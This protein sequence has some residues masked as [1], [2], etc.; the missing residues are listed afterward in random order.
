MIW[1]K[2]MS[3]N[4][5][6]SCGNCK[7]YVVIG[8]KY[9]ENC[10]E[11][12]SWCATCHHHLHSNAAKF[13]SECGSLQ[14]A[15]TTQAVQVVDVDKMPSSVE[16]ITK[17][18]KPSMDKLE[19]MADEINSQSPI[20]IKLFTQPTG[21]EDI[22]RLN[23]C[24]M[25]LSVFSEQPPMYIYFNITNIATLY[26]NAKPTAFQMAGIEAANHVRA[27]LSIVALLAGHH[28]RKAL[29]E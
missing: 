29:E 19:Y 18:E 27:M 20:V 21:M 11:Q 10:G 25:F 15:Q 17:K 7:E 13:C 26:V 5:T 8:D 6:A 28:K 12:N 1:N 16:S 2:E 14:T 24:L 22:S 9:C 23:Q 4:H 3:H